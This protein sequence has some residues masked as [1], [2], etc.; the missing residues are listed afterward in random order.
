MGWFTQKVDKWESDQQR[1][2]MADFVARLKAMDGAEI[3]NVVAVATHFR[4]SLEDDGHD[5]MDPIAYVA[6]NPGFLL[7]LS[8]TANRLKKQRKEQEAA[9]FMIWTNTARAGARLELRGLGRE[10]WRE[11][12]RGFPHVEEA[13]RDFRFRTGIG[14]NIVDAEQFPLGLTPEAT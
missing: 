1:A 14:L 9:A 6:V 8:T 4:H 3:G 7:F 11:L 2:E 10:M 13:A 12:S 5:P